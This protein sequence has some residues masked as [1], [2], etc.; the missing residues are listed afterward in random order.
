M[1]GIIIENVHVVPIGVGVLI[2]RHFGQ[3][4]SADRAISPYMQSNNPFDATQLDHDAAI[5]RK[6]WL[7]STRLR[8]A[9]EQMNVNCG[10]ETDGG[11]KH[12]GGC[13]VES[14]RGKKPH[15]SPVKF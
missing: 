4:V 5:S 14:R 2:R 3:R 10:D 11:W 7:L 1:R 12:T 15:A 9:P 8:T 13:E 6:P